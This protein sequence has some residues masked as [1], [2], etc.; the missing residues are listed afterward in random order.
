M[1]AMMKLDDAI[2][3][4]TRLVQDANANAT[5]LKTPTQAHTSSVCIFKILE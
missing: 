4:L 3:A 5:A 1:A 2:R